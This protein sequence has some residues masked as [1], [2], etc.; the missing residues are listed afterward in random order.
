M[1]LLG[2]LAASFGMGFVYFIGAIP[3]GAALNVPLWL[4]AFTA[5][6]GYSMGAVVVVLAGVPFRDWLTR[7]LGIRIDQENPGVVL[8]AWNRFG[9]PALGLLAPVTVGP[10]AGS[11]IALALGARRGPIVAAIA[12]GALPWAV[13]FAVLVGLGVKLVK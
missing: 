6:L 13:G 4:A 12:L 2:G 9:L 7:K 10:Q 5:W 3:A 1:K 8:R 11:L